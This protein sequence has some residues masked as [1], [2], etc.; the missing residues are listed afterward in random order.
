MSTASFGGYEEHRFTRVVLGDVETV[1]RKLCDV[2]EDF[3]YTVL[4]DSPI[5]VKRLRT[6]SVLSAT[7]LEYEGRLT[8]GLKAISEAS[9]LVTFDYAVPYLYSKADKQAL[10]REAEALIALATATSQ[11][12]CAGCGAGL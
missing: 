11:T 7:V 10:E 2:V 12:A 8:I 1:R 3:N 4:G 9:T 5:Q 6:K